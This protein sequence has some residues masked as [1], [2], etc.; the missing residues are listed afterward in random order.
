ME[1]CNILSW[2]VR[3]LNKKNKKMSILDV[4]RLNKF[5]IGA[6]L[7]TKVKGE[8]L[9]EVM[10]ST[11][12]GWDYYSSLRLEGRILL[13]WKASWVRI[14]A[15]QENDQFFNCRVRICNTNQDFCLT[16][17]YGSNQLEARRSL[18]YDLA[19]FI[20][21]VKPWVVLGDFNAI[22]D[23]ND[24]VGGRPISVKELED[25]R[26]WLDLCLVEELKIMGSYY[27]WSNNQEGGN[28]IYSKLD[29]MFSNEDWLDSFPN[30][31]AV[32][33]WEVVSDHC[34]ILLKQVAVKN[35]GVQPS[36]FY[37]MWAS[38]PQFRTTVLDNWSKPL[39]VEGC[40]LEQAKSNLY[41]DPN[42]SCLCAEERTTFL[43][44]KRQEKLYASFISQKRKI[45]W[46]HFG[47]ENSSFIHASLKKRKVANR[48]VKA[49]G[50][51]DPITIALGLVLNFDAQLELIKPFSILDVKSAMFSIKSI[52]SHGPDGFGSSFFKALW[53][54]IGKEVSLAVLDIFESGYAPKFL[55]NTILVSYLWLIILL[56][57][58]TI[59]LLRAGAF[60]QHRSLACTVLILQDL[61]KGY[62]RKHCSPR[63]LM[64][65]DINK[66]YDS[67]DW[68]F[69]ENLLKALRFPGRFIRWIM[70]C[71]RR[72]TYRLMMNGRIQGCFQG[73]KGLRQG[74]PISSM[75]FVIVMEYLTHLLIKTSK[76]KNFRFH[77]LCK[78]LNLISLCFGDDL[79]L[80][81]EGF[82]P[83]TYLGVPLRPTKWKAIDWE[84]AIIG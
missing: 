7:E 52:K 28:R 57:L 36:R 1:F 6:L 38:H 59:G 74:D 58:L 15:I 45:D 70:V 49:S 44:F 46:L 12:V 3:G 18:R 69:L 2:N 47:D 29:R 21:P 79:L 34:V 9:K 62:N 19:H 84:F 51:I 24:R 50:Y 48:I 68:D 20:F 54:D 11:F 4:C 73:G 37:N 22:F 40:G 16:V 31:T 78:S 83:L 71:L 60:I 77:P 75:L 39:K 41:N 53:K 17:V 80:L 10:C 61:I 42:N 8:M 55:N 81:A 67:I 13:I 66:A 76:E 32:S 5:G 25:A 82:F 64:K 56:M 30:V 65:I 27:M 72:T 63:C 26:Q 43:E 35:V 23:P 33:H 14:E